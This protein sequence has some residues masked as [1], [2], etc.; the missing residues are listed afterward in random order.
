MIGDIQV[1]TYTMDVPIQ[2]S[3]E[4]QM[5]GGVRQ[6]E[7]QPQSQSGMRMQPNLNQ[8]KSGGKPVVLIT[9]ATVSGDSIIILITH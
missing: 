8:S 4:S 6:I 9:G 5:Q 7:G 1:I 2:G 3:Q